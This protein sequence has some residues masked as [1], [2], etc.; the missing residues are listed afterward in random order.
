[1]LLMARRAHSSIEKLAGPSQIA[2]AGAIAAASW[3][4]SLGLNPPP[5][6]LRWHVEISLDVVNRPARVEFDEQRDTRFHIDIYSEEWGFLFCHVGRV[7]WIRITDIPFVH[8]RDDH[9]L[10][11]QT[12]ALDNIGELLR[13]VEQKHQ[14]YFFREHA[15]IRTNVVAAEHLIR[16]WLQQL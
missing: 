15:M 11:A 16:R 10:L 8:G 4:R 7:S 5:G 2:N 1:V 6:L 14:I 12:P 9:Q 13:A 3:L